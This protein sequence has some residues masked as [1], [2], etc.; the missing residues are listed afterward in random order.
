M[1]LPNRSPIVKALTGHAMIGVFLATVLSCAQS[2]RE[3]SQRLLVDQSAVTPHSQISD[4]H[5]EKSAAPRLKAHVVAFQEAENVPRKIIYEADISLVVKD[6]TAVE[7]QIAALL[8]QN[9]GYVAESTIDRTQG[10]QL[11]GRW[12]VRVPVENFDTFLNEVSK[13]GLAESRHQTA[14]DVT[15]EFVDLEAQINNKKKLE[16]RIVK[17]VEDSAAELKDVIE[18]ERELARVRGEIEQMEGRLRF[19]TNRTEL[20]TV[21]IVARE[22]QDYVPP[23]APT[24]VNRI[25]QAWVDSIAA[26]R[27]FGEN[28]SVAVV[29]ALPWIVVASVLLVPTAW[30]IRKRNALTK[31][32][33][34]NKPPE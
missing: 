33:A 13:L 24:F 25:R 9:N 4:A 15:E 10:E 17:L 11:S 12:R 30:Y 31:S 19:L 14:Q 21:S 34:I 20:T 27:E 8:Q 32:H 7:T 26:L 22:V 5:A 23:Q 1:S 28:F 18:V 2:A 29:Y 16:E 3:S 6:V